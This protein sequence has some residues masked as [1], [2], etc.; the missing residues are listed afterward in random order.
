[1]KA[2][3]RRRSERLHLTR[4]F[5]EDGADP[6]VFCAMHGIKRATLDKWLREYRRHDEPGEPPAHFVQVALSHPMKAVGSVELTIGNCRFTFSTLPPTE[7]L[8]TLI[9]G[10]V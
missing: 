9:T 2:R 4:K 8:K 1:M 3:L 7:Y 10:H 6:E 5:C